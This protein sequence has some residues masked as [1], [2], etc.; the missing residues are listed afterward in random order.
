MQSKELLTQDQLAALGCVAVESSLTESI[1]DQI[2]LKLSGMKREKLDHFMA[3]KMMDGR[4][5]TLEFLGL[6]ALKSAKRKAEFKK[7]IGELRHANSGRV[8]VIHGV[9]RK[10]PQGMIIPEAERVAKAVNL[11]NK[12]S[13]PVSATKIEKIAIE[14]SN[15]SSDLVLFAYKA[16]FKSHLAKKRRS[17]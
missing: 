4:I 3:G 8:S 12:K 1:V 14:L 11:K 13:L 5:T 9:W 2:I 15:S 6:T 10:G 16:W 17:K 7:V